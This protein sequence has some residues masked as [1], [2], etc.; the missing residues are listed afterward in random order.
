MIFLGVESHFL[1]RVVTYYNRL[2]GSRS[3]GSYTRSFDLTND[4]RLFNLTVP[5][6]GS[7]RTN[8]IASL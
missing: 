7:K 3:I 6:E 4:G 2:T 5:I 8:D 1:L